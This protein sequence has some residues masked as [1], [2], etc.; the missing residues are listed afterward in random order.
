MVASIPFLVGANL[1]N[2]VGST[3]AIGAS[4]LSA[5]GTA[6]MAG[7]GS[8][9]GTA[10][11]GLGGTFGGGLK[12]AGSG[13][14]SGN[15]LI[16]SAGNLSNLKGLGIN[17]SNL[18]AGSAD[19]VR[20]SAGHWARV[21]GEN[22]TIGGTPGLEQYFDRVAPLYETGGAAGGAGGEAAKAAKGF[23]NMDPKQAQ[24]WGKMAKEIGSPILKKVALMQKN[25]K[26]K[27]NR[28]GKLLATAAG[29][30]DAFA[31]GEQLS[32][33]LTALAAPGQGTDGKPKTDPKAPGG[34][35][36]STSLNIGPMNFTEAFA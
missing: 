29:A 36:G 32:R 7:L 2:T 4:A 10:A 3:A 14:L 30:M 24:F 27:L 20:G 8:G 21:A 5:G 16:A 17:S 15:N 13:L 28:T 25:K 12:I 33:D 1:M 31:A 19:V 11:T 9:L 6:A 22:A 26:G 34:G 23:L 35:E 18:I